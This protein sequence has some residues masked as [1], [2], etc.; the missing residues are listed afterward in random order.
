MSW[1]YDA[2]SGVYRNHALS[3]E[4]RREAMYDVQTMRYLRPESGYGKRKGD[5]ITITRVMQLPVAGRVNELDVLPSGRPAINTKSV[6]VSE[7]GFKC[8]TTE[9]ERDLT[10]FDMTNQFQQMLRDQMSLTMD[11]MST[12][13]LK[14]TPYVYTP[15]V[16]GGVFSTNGTAAGTATANLAIS[17]LR[18]IRDQLR[19]NKAPYFRNSAYVGILSTRAA[20]G[21]KNDPE[22]K[23]W[24]A[25]QTAEPMIAGRMKDVEGFTLL[26]TN[27]VWSFADLIGSSTVCGDAIFFG[28]DPGFL[29][30]V[31]QPEL[32]AGIPTD[33][34]RFQ[35][36]G[37]VGTIEASITWDIASLAR[38]IK[39][40]ST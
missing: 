14:T 9:F 17:D 38:V 24:I 35:E 2:P 13:A 4:I 39:L 33:L 22:Y 15:E 25:E 11:L 27:N 6:T 21:I 10:S 32:R 23:D 16:G 20:R 28:M 18:Q 12:Q 8:S 30:V 29:A 19:K 36:V 7:W 40:G 5:T 37:W 31:S 34:G 3:S 26:E 1:T